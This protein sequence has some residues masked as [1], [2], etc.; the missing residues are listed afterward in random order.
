MTLVVRGTNRRRQSAIRVGGPNFLPSLAY[1]PTAI[2][3]Q[4][5]K[6]QSDRRLP[7]PRPLT[8]RH[9]AF[10]ALLDETPRG[11]TELGR[12]V[13]VNASQATSA[14]H[15]LATRGLADFSP[16]VGWTRP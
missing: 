2:K 9:L 10:A 5:I 3:R 8:D 11:Q 12:K 4:G 14:L 15:V 16:G 6:R 1:K 7:P 13:G